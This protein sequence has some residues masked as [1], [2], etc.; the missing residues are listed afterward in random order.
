MFYSTHKTRFINEKTLQVVGLS[1]AFC[2]GIR[3]VFVVL[4]LFAC[5]YFELNP[6]PKKFP[7]FP[8]EFKQHHCTQ[9]YKK[10][11]LSKPIKLL[12]NMT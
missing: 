7:S 5:G 4:M 9:F 10:Y 3:F 6:G 1:S 8:L 11:I 2:F 12:I